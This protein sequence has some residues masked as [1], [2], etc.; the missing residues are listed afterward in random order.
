MNLIYRYLI[1]VLIALPLFKVKAQCALP[2][3]FTGNTGSYM[4]V[5]F[6]SGAIEALPLTSDSPYIV[7][8]TPDGLIVGSASVASTDLIGGQ[9]SLAVWGDDTATPE[10]DGASA[11]AAL[12]FQL[13]DGSS[14]YDLNLSFAGLNSFTANA[15]L[16][17]IAASAELNCSDSDSD[18]S[19]SCDLPQPFIGGFGISMSL[20]FNSDAYFSLPISNPNAYIVAFTSDNLIVGGTTDIHD[21]TGNQ[22]MI[23]IFPND[24]F[25]PEVNGAI[26]G[27][28]IYFQLVGLTRVISSFLI[29]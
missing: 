16:P 12:T 24:D 8:F 26:E 6:T 10:I 7:A 27:E 4:T 11:G 1:V 25:T 2:Q 9:Q 14:L 21:L 15:S 29:K 13:V 17:V 19:S 5:F 20:L 23:P 3:P 18:S 28:T 22:F